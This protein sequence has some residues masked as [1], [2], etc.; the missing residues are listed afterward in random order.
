MRRRSLLH[1]LV[2]VPGALVGA[3]TAHAADGGE[4]DAPPPGYAVSTGQ[5]QAAV[6][7]RFPLRY[8]VPGVLDLELRTPRLRPLPEQ[9]R[10]LAEMAL[11]ASGPALHQTHQGSFDVDFALRYEASDRT[12]RAQELR[13]SRL[14]FPSLRPDVV[15]LLDA[16]APAMAAQSLR[17]VV[18]HQLQPEDLKAIDAMGMQPGEITVTDT[19]LRIGLVLK[20]L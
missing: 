8:P 3:V 18:L 15:R 20:P 13:L 6:A 17:E 19:G 12:V 1:S 7:Q 14:R 11:E 9:N 16:Y 4:Q 5:L 10:L 2:L